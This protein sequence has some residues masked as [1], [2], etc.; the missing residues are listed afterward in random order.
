MNVNNWYGTSNGGYTTKHLIFSCTNTTKTSETGFFMP[1]YY[2]IMYTATL[3]F[4]GPNMNIQL[5]Y[6]IQQ[7][8]TVTN[9]KLKNIYMQK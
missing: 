7:E 4:Y 3:V 2:H 1:R 8:R 5:F 6:T 9:M